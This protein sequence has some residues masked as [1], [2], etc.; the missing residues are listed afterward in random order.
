MSGSRPIRIITALAAL[1]LLSACASSGSALTARPSLEGKR[2]LDYI[3]AV[4]ASA[5]GK[6]V[7][8]V[9]VNPPQEHGKR[10]GY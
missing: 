4:E 9:W 1:G 5:R 2:D 7:R 8:V 10:Y 6:G 3:A